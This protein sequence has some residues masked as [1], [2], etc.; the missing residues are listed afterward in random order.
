MPRPCSAPTPQRFCVDVF[1]LFGPHSRGKDF[2][3]SGAWGRPEYFGRLSKDL[4]P[5]GQRA[6]DLENDLWFAQHLCDSSAVAAI[7]WLSVGG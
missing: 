3:K 6:T 1:S 4:V 5:C 2:G 7:L